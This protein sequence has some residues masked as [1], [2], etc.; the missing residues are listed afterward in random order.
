MNLDGL[1][2]FS[3]PKKGICAQNCCAAEGLPERNGT[4]LFQT[5][6]RDLTETLEAPPSTRA[7]RLAALPRPTA[8]P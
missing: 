6:N 1:P 3:S 2:L 7:A 8:A 4:T 5:N